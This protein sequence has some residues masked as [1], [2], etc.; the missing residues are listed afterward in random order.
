MAV[1]YGGT[2][3]S[4]LPAGLPEKMR[5]PGMSP[6]KQ[7]VGGTHAPTTGG[8]VAV[9]LSTPATITLTKPL[10]DRAVISA[11]SGVRLLPR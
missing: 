4:S 9:L 1:A 3:K 10:G 8:C 6:P 5:G 7:V 2:V 11:T